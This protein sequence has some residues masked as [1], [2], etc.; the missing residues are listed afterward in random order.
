MITSTRYR[1]QDFAQ[2]FTV[3]GQLPLILDAVMNENGEI[4]W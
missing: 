2:K 1:Q 3:D 4:V